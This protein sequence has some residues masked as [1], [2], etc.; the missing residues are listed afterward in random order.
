MAHLTPIEY[1]IHSLLGLVDSGGIPLKSAPRIDQVRL[2]AH[3]RPASAEVVVAGSRGASATSLSTL[4]G[5]ERSNRFDRH[6]HDPLAE[7]AADKTVALVEF[8]GVFVY[9]VGNDASRSRDFGRCK[10]SPQSIDQER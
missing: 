1:G 9:G 5:D 6:Q 3:P 4:R 7:R 10:A 8:H 2:V